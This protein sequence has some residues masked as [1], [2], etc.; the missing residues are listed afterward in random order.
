MFAQR[1]CLS[2]VLLAAGPAS[3]QP[4]PPTGTVPDPPPPQVRIQ[5]RTP[6]AVAPEKP[7]GYR[8]IVSNPSPERAYKVR[9]RCP[10]PDTVTPL[11]AEPKGATVGK[12]QVWEIGELPGGS[13]KELELQLQP[14]PGATEVRVQ[15]FVS[16]EYG[17]AVSTKVEA[18]KLRVDK[19]AAK[20]AAAGDP[21]PVSIRVT[22]TGPVPV[23]DLRLTETVTD[24]FTFDGR[25]GGKRGSVPG[26][27]E[28]DLGTLPPGQSKLVRY[29]VVG[30]K[31]QLR[32]TTAV[33]G[34]G[35]T[36]VQRLTETEVLTPGLAVEL[37]GPP[38]VAGG[39]RGKYTVVVKNTGTLPLEGVK[40]SASLPPGCA[41]KKVTN[42]SRR[43]RDAV[44][45]TQPHLDPG[46][47]F[48]YRFELDSATSGKKTVRAG[49]K[50]GRGT[51]ATGR[52][53]ITTFEGTSQLGLR[54]DA[55]PAM[56]A[57]G[58]DG[59]LTLTV[60]NAGTEPAR[61]AR[62]R[63][64]LPDGVRVVQTT[65]KDVQATKSEVLFPAVTVAP[66]EPQRFTLTYTPSK[67]G[68]VYFRTTLEAPGLGDRPLVKEQAVEVVAK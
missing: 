16:S 15:A 20:S 6:S 21:I 13:T 56:P 5:V 25:D 48:A 60:T 45:W 29:A 57:V 31:P 2:A 54:A 66:G 52:E 14:K 1:F 10:L 59:L 22:N 34:H 30:D 58:R 38:S 8:L 32:A 27:R 39:E 37:D 36:Q 41:V 26:Q 40:V 44:E 9:V 47:T 55:E 4:E 7:I 51:E 62:L 28:W 3:A 23:L 46:E 61:N 49:A 65:P 33:Q 68:T 17:Q 35:V 19:E 53:V 43:P 11:K 12:E 18:P 67:A 50:A 64:E 63:V 42:G 24:G